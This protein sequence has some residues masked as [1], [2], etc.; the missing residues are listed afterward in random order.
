[1]EN[2]KKNIVGLLRRFVSISL[3]IELCQNPVHRHGKF[4]PINQQ[5]PKKW[6]LDLPGLTSMELG[7]LAAVVA[8]A[9]GKCCYGEMAFAGRQTRNQDPAQIP[10][11]SRIVQFSG[12]L[13]RTARFAALFR[14]AS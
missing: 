12:M 6:L 2:V 14:V 1:M 9:E 3:E 7:V 8:Q 10:S 4:V 11:G 5:F 13:P